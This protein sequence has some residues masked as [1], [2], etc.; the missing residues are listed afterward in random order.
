MK[1][2]LSFSFIGILMIG[3]VGNDVPYKKYGD[4][5][6][7]GFASKVGYS[8]FQIKE[9]QWKVTYTG[10]MDSNPE[11]AMQYMY[12]RAKEVCLKNGY[13]DFDVVGENQLEKNNGSQHI[14]YGYTISNNQPV[15]TCTVICK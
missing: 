4:S 14:G 9:N 11:L 2:T 10:A 5:T 3:C 13:K 15:S 7:I 1:K 12:K 8:D 6:G